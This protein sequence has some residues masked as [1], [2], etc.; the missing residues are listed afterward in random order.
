MKALPRLKLRLY[1]R[2][3]G[4]LLGNLDGLFGNNYWY[5]SLWTTVMIPAGIHLKAKKHSVKGI[6]KAMWDVMKALKF[7]YEHHIYH[8][9]VSYSN[10]VYKNQRLYRNFKFSN[11]IILISF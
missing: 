2:D 8:H 10:I 4:E 3:F 9:D 1:G 5:S 6:L 11:D 7:S